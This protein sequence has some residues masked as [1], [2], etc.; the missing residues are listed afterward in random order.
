[1]DLGD[2]NRDQARPFWSPDAVKAALISAFTCFGAVASVHRGKR[3]A[4]PLLGMADAALTRQATVALC[5]ATLCD[6]RSGC[7]VQGSSLELANKTP[8]AATVAAAAACNPTP[9]DEAA[10]TS[11]IAAAS[12]ERDAKPPAR[13]L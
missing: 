8:R 3:F 9:M 6:I 4:T 5:A 7:H 13:G 1:V 2:A 12:V 11:S 10:S